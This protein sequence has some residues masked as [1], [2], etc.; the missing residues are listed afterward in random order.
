MIVQNVID[1]RLTFAAMLTEGVTLLHFVHLHIGVHASKFEMVTKGHS[2]AEKD[3][4]DQWHSV[5]M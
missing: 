4:C 3:V 1:D 2:E 5:I